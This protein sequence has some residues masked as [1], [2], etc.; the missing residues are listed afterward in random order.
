MAPGD[1]VKPHEYKGQEITITYDPKRCIHAK[2]CVH[3]APS[4]FNPNDK[5]WVHPDAS[6]AHRTAEVIRACP[7]GA[8]HYHAVDESLAEHPEA[9]NT[10]TVR[11]DGPL[12]VRGNA[13]I[14]TEAGEPLLS[15][16][17]VALCR[18]GASNN[19]PFCDNGHFAIAFEDPGMAQP[20]ADA[21]NEMVTS[22]K[23]HLIPT[24]NGP[25]HLQGQVTIRN[26]AHEVVFEGT[27]AWLC[28][29]GASASKPFC[30]GSHVK[31]GFKSE[32][33]PLQDA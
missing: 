15:D 23:L 14:V 4:A 29:C 12:H 1:P 22:G 25:L 16:T 28:R 5:P 32:L 17:R 11:P 26:A 33:K 9:S 3:G 10:V 7:T 8:L 2:E 27:E 31:I 13:L 30:D 20:G 18:C 19:K 24:A 6:P 21:K